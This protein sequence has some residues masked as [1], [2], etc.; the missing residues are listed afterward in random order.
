MMPMVRPDRMIELLFMAS[1]LLVGF[2]VSGQRGPIAQTVAAFCRS[3]CPAIWA[4][5]WRDSD[6]LPLSRKRAPDVT[7]LT[8]RS[9]YWG[10]KVGA[11]SLLAR[12][13]G[14]GLRCPR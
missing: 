3:R 12:R 13:F 1:P 10:V 8:G 4:N 14:S 7:K 6:V 9:L 11:G 5:S 2:R